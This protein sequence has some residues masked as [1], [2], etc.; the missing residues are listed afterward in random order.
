M[1]L[2]ET[3][4]TRARR[5]SGSSAASQPHTCSVPDEGRASVASMRMRVVLPAPLEPKTLRKAPWGSSKLKRSTAL[6]VPN[7]LVSLAAQMTGS[8]LRAAPRGARSS[9]MGGSLL[10]RAA[11]REHAQ[12]TTCHQSNVTNPHN[13][14][15]RVYP[16]RLLCLPV[17]RS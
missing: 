5:A 13:A 17:A 4:P 3:R 11:P 15:K 12:R 16:H 8:S 2:C 10:P 1:G 6:R 9:L 7:C 14:D